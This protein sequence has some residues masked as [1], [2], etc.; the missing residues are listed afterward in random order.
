MSEIQ[1]NKL[2]PSSGTAVQ[3]GDSGDTFTIPS[4]ATFTN[5]GTATG[6]G[7]ANTPYF[8]AR[9][10]ASQSNIGTNNTKV[11]FN[12]R[13]IDSNNLFDTTNHRF[14]PTTAGTYFFNT[15]QRL[16]SSTAN[17]NFTCYLFKNGSN[18]TRMVET[19]D[20][21]ITYSAFTCSAMADAN[22]SSDYF[23][24]YVN[25]SN[26]QADITADPSDQSWGFFEGFRL[27]S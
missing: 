16:Y 13:V 10:T 21:Q 17:T 24:I 19:R 11:A 12:E 4:G 22:G 23:E 26:N 1:A 18:H 25:I 3:L 7:G 20:S 9:L 14:L 5:N 27:I 6:F 15:S 2:S 8:R